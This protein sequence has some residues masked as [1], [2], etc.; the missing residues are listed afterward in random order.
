VI[1]FAQSVDGGPVKIGTAVDVDRRIAQLEAYYGRQLAV[2]AILPGGPDEEAAIH[3]RFAHLRLDG[4][5][6]CGRQPEQFRPAADLMAFIGKPLF[7]NQGDVELMEGSDPRSIILS[8]KGEAEYRAWLNE[9]ADYCRTTSVG[10]MDLA[11]VHY[12][13]HVKFPKP[14]PKRTRGR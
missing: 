4:K 1:Y 7:V 6:R 13:M 5:G 8:F 10:V 3:E 11:L 9:L 14:A 2:L 12:A